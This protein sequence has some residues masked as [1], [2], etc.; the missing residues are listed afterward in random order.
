MNKQDKIPYVDYTIRKLVDWYI[1][2]YG[3]ET[4]DLS[5]LKVLKLIFFITAIDT[6]SNSKDSLLDTV[7]DKFYAMPYGHVESDVYSIIRN[8]SLN[9][10]VVNNQKTSI[11]G[12]SNYNLDEN[13]TSQISDSI[14]KLRSI[15]PQLIELTSFDLVDLSHSWYSWQYYYSIARKK[16]LNSIEID[17]QVIKEEDKIFAL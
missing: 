10:V 14:A 8:N 5:T 4:N 17:N 11:K 12:I 1:E 6:S 2:I 15:N 3:K 9:N 13:L 7:F 16:G